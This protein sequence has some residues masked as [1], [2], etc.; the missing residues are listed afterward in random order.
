MGKP[1]TAR[2]QAEVPTCRGT[3]Q[4]TPVYQLWLFQRHHLHRLRRHQ[5][6][7]ECKGIHAGPPAA[8]LTGSHCFRSY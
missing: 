3:V 1:A 6:A 5:T 4:N 8:N 7:R 2:T